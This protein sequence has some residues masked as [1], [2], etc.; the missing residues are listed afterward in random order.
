[1]NDR[2]KTAFERWRSENPHYKVAEETNLLIDQWV[3]AC[4]VLGRSLDIYYDVGEYWE[5]DHSKPAPDMVK[6]V[7]NY[8]YSRIM[9]GNWTRMPISIP[10][11]ELPEWEKTGS[12]PPTIDG[13]RTYQAEIAGL[14]MEMLDTNPEVIVALIKQQLEERYDHLKQLAAQPLEAF[15]PVQWSEEAANEEEWFREAE[16]LDEVFVIY[17]ELWCFESGIEELRMLTITEEDERFSL[18]NTGYFDLLV[19]LNSPHLMRV[20][21]DAEPVLKKVLRHLASQ[22]MAYNDGRPYLADKKAAPEAFWWR[23]WIAQQSQGRGSGAG[24]APQ[25]RNR[26]AKSSRPKRS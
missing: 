2:T 9:T 16:R 6:L 17:E 1:M 23:H 5:K 13:I 15:T 7:A 12:L 25:H 19:S 14:F 24:K 3:D 20:L 8:G 11:A 10:T 21:A 26:S 4:L 22:K 18:P